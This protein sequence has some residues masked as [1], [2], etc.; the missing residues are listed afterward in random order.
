MDTSKCSMNLFESNN[1]GEI[2]FTGKRASSL[3][4]KKFLDQEIY[5][6]L[7]RCVWYVGNTCTNS[8][9]AGV[10]SDKHK[11]LSYLFFMNT[12]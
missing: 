2:N 4:V 3:F 5:F 1:V 12:R 7:G 10:C 6:A 9:S 8:K 11:N